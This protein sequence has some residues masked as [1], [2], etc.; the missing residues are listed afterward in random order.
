[1]RFGFAAMRGG[2]PLARTLQ[3]NREIG[4][5]ERTIPEFPIRNLEMDNPMGTRPSD[6]KL[7]IS[8]WKFRN[9]RFRNFRFPNSPR[10]PSGGSGRC[11]CPISAPPL[12][13]WCKFKR[14]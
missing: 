12:D 13:E 4:N 11:K 2:R 14:R 6:L 10:S 5:F 7:H 9:V 8:D 1:M 3:G